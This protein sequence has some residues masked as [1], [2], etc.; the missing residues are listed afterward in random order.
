VNGQDSVTAQVT[1]EAGRVLSSRLPLLVLGLPIAWLFWTACIIDIEYYDGYDTI[2]NTLYFCGDSDGYIGNRAPLIAMLLVPARLL[3]RLFSDDPLHVR[4]YHL[5][6]AFVHVLY[7]L[8]VAVCMRRF[9]DSRGARLIAF[10]SAVLSVIFFSYAPFLSHDILPG[11]LLLLMLLVVEDFVQKPK[12][13]QW[14]LL[15]SLGSAAVLIKQT[16]GIFWIAILASRAAPFATVKGRLERTQP[17]A[18]VWLALGAVA[19]AVV[20]WLV[21]AF[22]LGGAY[23]S[24]TCLLRPLR[25][26]RHVLSQYQ[27]TTATFPLWLY[28]RNAP[29]YGLLTTVLI[30]PGLWM[31]LKQD[32]LRQSLAVSWIVC[33]AFLHLLG[34]RE[35]RYAAFLA[36]ISAVVVAH[37]LA[38]ILRGGRQRHLMLVGLILAVDVIMAASEAAR[39]AAPFYRR[40]ELREFLSVL[41]D[42]HGWRK[43]VLTWNLMGFMPPRNSPLAGDRY[44]RMFHFGTH[45]LQILY[46]LPRADVGKARDVNW[47]Q[48]QACRLQRSA[49]LFTS[50]LLYNGPALLPG[51]PVTLADYAMFACQAERIE[52][53]GAAIEWHTRPEGAV[54]AAPPAGTQGTYVRFDGGGVDKHVFDRYLFPC[55]WHAAERRSYA[56]NRG[57]DGEYRVEGIEDSTQLGEPSDCELWGYRIQRMAVPALERPGTVLLSLE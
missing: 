35:V 52:F 5:A 37:P 12:L 29:F 7:L 13:A 17:S 49:L 31:L 53:P 14:L 57:A 48:T 50:K 54:D 6:M 47:L 4:T 34:M 24:T 43:P 41:R 1:S 11:L 3:S 44:H 18:C 39:V 2:C 20:Y 27:G 16:Y 55:L 10:V 32:R 9:V 19:S 8:G 15:V 22:V 26:I 25:Q 40:S 56:L 42:D 21:M 38:G 28:I 23:P 30:L 51:P 36:P 45:H 33:F 46:G